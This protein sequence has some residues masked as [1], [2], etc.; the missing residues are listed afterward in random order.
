M[1]GVAGLGG[2]TKSGAAVG[3]H[4][5]C[6]TRPG[7]QLVLY[8]RSSCDWAGD[9]LWEPPESGVT[10]P[11][12]EPTAEMLTSCDT[13]RMDPSSMLPVTHTAGHLIAY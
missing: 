9:S 5:R 4:A 3:L 7:M 13:H 2:V 10:V 12:L 8:L 11:P 1:A 6:D